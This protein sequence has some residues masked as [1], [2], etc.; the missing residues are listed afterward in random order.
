M[1]NITM[2]TMFVMMLK[3][4][5]YIKCLG[6]IKASFKLEHIGALLS[7]YLIDVFSMVFSTSCAF[8]KIFKNSIIKTLKA[9]Y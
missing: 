4:N 9:T 7:S 2:M 1:M 3:I 6:Y 8:Q 5:K